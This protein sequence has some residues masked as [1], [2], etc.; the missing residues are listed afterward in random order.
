MNNVYASPTFNAYTAPDPNSS[1][2]IY[3]KGGMQVHEPMEGSTMALMMLVATLQWQA[4]MAGPTY[5]NA[6]AQAGKAAYIVSG[7]Q[8]AQDKVASIAA[9]NAGD[10]LHSIGITDA[11]LGVVLGTAK[12]IR[13][14]SVDVN[15][16]RLGHIR[17]HLTATTN[18]A[19][20]GIR[21]EW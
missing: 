8:G 4:P 2:F 10:G 13:D 9:K 19:S 3:Y 17:T 16:P 11:E 18:N 21:Y 7:G 6:A 14:K 20:L 1:Y 12:V 5:S 15:G